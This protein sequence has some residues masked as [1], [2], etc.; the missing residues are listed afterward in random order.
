MVNVFGKVYISES[1]TKWVS[2]EFVFNQSG[3]RTLENHR[4]DRAHQYLSAPETDGEAA[5][6]TFKRRETPTPLLREWAKA[7]LMN[8]EWKDALSAAASVN[9][10]ISLHWHPCD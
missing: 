7:T 8:E 1:I 2:G 3:G 5:S 9:I 10:Y 6:S 4:I